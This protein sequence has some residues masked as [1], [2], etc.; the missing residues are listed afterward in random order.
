MSNATKGKSNQDFR[1]YT[2]PNETIQYLKLGIN[3]SNP[4]YTLKHIA[5]IN[6][7]AFYPIY[8]TFF[9]LTTFYFTHLM[10]ASF[11]LEFFRFYLHYLMLEDCTS[12]KSRTTRTVKYD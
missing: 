11:Q 2:K 5:F 9:L 3:V 10:D 7:L 4:E 1:N 12:L 8:L 6:N